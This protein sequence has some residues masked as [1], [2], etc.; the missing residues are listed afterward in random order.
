MIALNLLIEILA[1]LQ[2]ALIDFRF[3]CRVRRLNREIKQ[4]KRQVGERLIPTLKEIS[5]QFEKFNSDLEKP[6]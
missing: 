5:H 1:R 3:K 4:L 2:N 6:K